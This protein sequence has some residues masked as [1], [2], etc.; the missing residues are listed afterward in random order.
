[1]VLPF[2]IGGV[3]ITLETDLT[4]LQNVDIDKLL[5]FNDDPNNTAAKY[6]YANLWTA[7]FGI[8]KATAQSDAALSKLDYELCYAERSEYW[9]NIYAAKPKEDNDKLTEKKLEMLLDKDSEVIESKKK[10][11][12]ATLESEKFSALYWAFQAMANRANSALLQHQNIAFSESKIQNN[13]NEF[14]PTKQN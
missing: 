5:S 2:N 14:T 8:I 4:P 6:A 7:Q 13:F 12:A 3:N 1:M 9:R 11:I 10:F